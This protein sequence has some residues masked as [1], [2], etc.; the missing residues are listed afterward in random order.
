MTV[1]PP[2]RVE[3]RQVD[4]FADAPYR[5]NG[6]VVAFCETLDVAAERLRL[7]AEEMRQFETIFV[8]PVAA[9]GRSVEARIFTVEEELPFAGHPVV[10]AAAALHERVAPDADEVEW[11]FLIQG[12]PLRVVSH[13]DD[14][15]YDATMDQGIPVPSEP[16][17]E[18]REEL[19]RALDLALDDLAPLP[20]QVI[21]TGLP[22]LIVPVL[23]AALGKARITTGGFES[24]LASLGAKFVY[25][26]DVEHREGRTW[27]NSG[28]VE[29]VATGSAA[30]PAAA[31]LHHHRLADPT[32]PL[33]LAQGRF[34]GRPSSITV[35]HGPD[36]HLWV[37][38]RVRPV[39][40]GTFDA[41]P[42][43]CSEP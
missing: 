25:V 30:G 21:S 9:G 28:A 6:L 5:G 29:D 7:V 3:Y 13:R 1:V 2:L 10:G 17:H 22:Y 40:S 14:A 32:K 19:A 8:G 12:R 11:Q 15:Y 41:F 26:L 23:A 4:V 37:G 20:L 36:G 43:P 24:T 16:L 42:A 27:D 31:Y 35:T 33:R 18:R 38:G 39:A 34:V